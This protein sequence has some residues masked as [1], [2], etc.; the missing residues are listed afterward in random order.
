M[1]GKY[2]F[3]SRY[4]RNARH[5]STEDI[6]VHWLKNWWATPP[7]VS[8]FLSV[9]SYGEYQRHHQKKIRRRTEQHHDK[10]LKDEIPQVLENF[11]KEEKMLDNDVYPSALSWIRR[12]V[13]RG[14]SEASIHKAFRERK[15]KLFDPSV[16]RVRRTKKDELLS[17]GAR[18]FLPR[19]ILKQ[20]VEIG[21]KNREG[22]RNGIAGLDLE[23][24][25]RMA[26]YL[27][28]SVLLE[29][30]QML[31][32]NKPGGLAVQGGKGIKLSLDMILNDLQSGN[33]QKVQK[34]RNDSHSMLISQMDT[35][36]AESELKLVHRLDRNATGALLLAKGSLAA[37]EITKAFSCSTKIVNYLHQSMPRDQ[38]ITNTP[39]VLKEYWAICI[40]DATNQDRNLYLSKNFL[41]KDGYKEGSRPFD[42]NE[43]LS[44]DYNS[45]DVLK[46]KLRIDHRLAHELLATDKR[47]PHQI[48]NLVMRSDKESRLIKIPIDGLPAE[49]RAFELARNN[50]F[51]LIW[52]SLMPLTG[53]KHQLRKHCSS[54]DGL[55][56]SILGDAKYGSTR[57]IFQKQLLNYLMESMIGKFQGD[58]LILEVLHTVKTPPLF[59]HCRSLEV[60]LRGREL[61]K[62][63]APAPEV[64]EYVFTLPGWSKT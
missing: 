36:G 12:T 6:L 44:M 5:Y 48:N 49:T 59:L 63:T 19:T 30:D 50:Y 33:I 27:K 64:W 41:T 34:K 47:Y 46:R 51:G 7:F 61:V 38:K 42:D 35:T 1:W 24:R 9:S 20:S 10:I 60:K 57:K 37:A 43:Y 52:Y 3:C 16:G 62:I 4:V 56:T 31:C 15:V 53:R 13:P 11:E 29:T 2:E 54:P 26:D 23:L 21:K 58:N 8:P 25:Q 39:C 14:V 17:E 22:R 45:N 40:D 32:L 28:S 18:I 55:N